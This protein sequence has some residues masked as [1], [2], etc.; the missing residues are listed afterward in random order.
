FKRVANI[1]KDIDLNSNLSVDE[2]LFEQDEE[3]TLFANYSKIKDK[4]FD[5]FEEELDALF[6]LK[7]NLD[8]FFEKVF[9]NHEDEKIKTNRKNLISQVYLGF[10]NIADIKEI[11]I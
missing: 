1:V 3:K 4:K 10:R 8:N 2:R 5:S 11:T 6:S 7:T 9:V